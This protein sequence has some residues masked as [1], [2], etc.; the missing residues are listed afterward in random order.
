MVRIA[1]SLTAFALGALAA[2]G[3]ASCGSDDAQLLA[4][5]TA[6]EITANLDSVRE[7][8]DAGDCVGAEGA[9]QQVSE[10][11][12][13][14][15]G[16]DRKLKQALTQGAAKLNEVVA[17]CEETEAE[18]TETTESTTAESTEEKPEKKKDEK[19]SKP[20]REAGEPTTTETAPTAP[21][22]EGNGTGEGGGSPGGG[23]SAPEE[24]PSGGVS[25][26]SAVGEGE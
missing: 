4:G 11:V 10:Q 7:L 5:E 9:A 17:S 21:E 20:D 8:A 12:E 3:I 24:S 25:P 26:G 13:D 14:L 6:R 15:E 16:V 23:E 18:T 2:A 22:G 19:E 1:L